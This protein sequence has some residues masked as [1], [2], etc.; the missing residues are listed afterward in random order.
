VTAK[1]QPQEY[2]PAYEIYSIVRVLTTEDAEYL[3]TH[4]YA[5]Y[6]TQQFQP[7]DLELHWKTGSYIVNK[8]HF[9]KN[10]IPI[11]RVVKE[12]GRNG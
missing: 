2:V 10:F 5:Q 12:K 3:N 7:G 11:K 6:E 9:E 1:R 4:Q 8:E